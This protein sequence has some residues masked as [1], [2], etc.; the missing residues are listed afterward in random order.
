MCRGVAIGTRR[1]RRRGSS[2]YGAPRMADTYLSRIIDAH[3][4][5]DADDTRSESE[6]FALAQLESP[7]RGFRDALGGPGVSVI[8]EVKRRSPS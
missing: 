3:R 2:E 4:R 1:T 5:A 7:T 8:A 6:L